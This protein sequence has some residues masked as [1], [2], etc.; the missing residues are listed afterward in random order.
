MTQQHRPRFRRAA[1]VAWIAYWALLFTSTHV[2]VPDLPDLP[3]HSDKVVHFCGYAI[4]T[5]LGAFATSRGAVRPIRTLL[6][7]SAIFLLY[8]VLDEWLQRFVNRT[9]SVEDFFADAAG[10]L[11]GG[12]AWLIYQ[13][14]SPSHAR[15][16]L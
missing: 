8:G 11:A 6:L 1:L 13:R 2:P 3:E 12:V 7:W 15:T 14:F 16:A 5:L 9:P 10:I 4:L